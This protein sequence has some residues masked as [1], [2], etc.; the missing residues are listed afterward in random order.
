MF[1]RKIGNQS[2]VTA[3]Q[4]SLLESLVPMCCTNPLQ[5]AVLILSRLLSAL[6][7]HR[8]CH[9][10]LRLPGTDLHC[11]VMHCTVLH[12]TA[13]HCTVLHGTTLHCSVLQ[14]TALQCTESVPRREEGSTG[15][16]LHEV[17]GTPKTECWYFPV[18]P[19][20]ESRYRHYPI[21][22]SDEASVIAIAKVMSRAIAMSKPRAKK[23][24]D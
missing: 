17:E 16:Y 1:L 4:N 22:N 14:C 18:Y 12:C 21:Y 11:T 19:W 24:T 23:E 15:K 20:L 7:T 8:H 13:L 10:S 6:R 3:Q 2:I 5:C 9:R